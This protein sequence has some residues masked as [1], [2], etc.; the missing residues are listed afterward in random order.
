MVQCRGIS[1]IIEV[2]RKTRVNAF[3]KPT[4]REAT[5]PSLV[6]RGKEWI[7][8]GWQCTIETQGKYEVEA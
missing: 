4:A 6:T 7:V 3:I 1:T 2:V 8:S 5:G